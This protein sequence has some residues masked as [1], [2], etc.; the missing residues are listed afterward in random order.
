MD[1]Q[2]PPN[3]YLKIKA[4]EASSQAGSTTKAQLTAYAGVHLLR[5]LKL[6]KSQGAFDKMTLLQEEKTKPVEDNKDE[7]EFYKQKCINMQTKIEENMCKVEEQWAAQEMRYERQMESREMEERLKCM[8]E[9]MS[10]MQEA[11]EERAAC[12]NAMIEETK[13][14]LA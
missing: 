10:Y 14:N 8:V 4:A 12:V 9:E 1:R 11:I 5:E 2:V 7:V 6:L 3:V 13:A